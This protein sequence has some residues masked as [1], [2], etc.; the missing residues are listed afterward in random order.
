[1]FLKYVNKNYAILHRQ[2]YVRIFKGCSHRTSS[3]S[4]EIATRTD[5][6]AGLIM[7]NFV[8][9]VEDRDA[10]QVSI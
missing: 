9:N 2:K 8:I 3:F 4:E 6:S 1:M 7:S 10:S 5:E